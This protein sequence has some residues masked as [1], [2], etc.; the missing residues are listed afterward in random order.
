[1]FQFDNMQNET[2]NSETDR[3]GLFYSRKYSDNVEQRSIGDT[4][5]IT[6]ENKFKASKSQVSNVSVGVDAVSQTKPK[7]YD[8]CSQTRIQPDK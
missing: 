7:S 4:D 1:M 8:A 3:I 5:M 2:G 6:A